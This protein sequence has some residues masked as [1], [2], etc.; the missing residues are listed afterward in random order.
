MAA[1]GVADGSEGSFADEG[2]GFEEIEAAHVVPDG[3]HGAAG[4]AEFLEV[5][6]VVGK[7][8]VGGREA[9]V[10]A[11]DEFDAV[12]VVGAVAEADDD[13]VTGGVGLVQGEDSKGARGVGG[14]F[15]DEQVGG[16]AQAGLGLV[17]EEFAGVVAAV[18]FFLNFDV[19]IA[20]FFG[21]GQGAH[22]ILHGAQDGGALFALPIVGSGR[23][24]GGERDEARRRPGK[25]ES[26]L[27]RHASL[28][29]LPPLRIES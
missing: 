6:R 2:E 14:A 24:K 11:P 26:A 22:D 12:F 23:R 7:Q 16:D 13:F 21:A 28:M 4:V 20:A 27:A 19:E 18:G 5:G 1:E 17:G 10:A 25:K 15:R 8:R 3:F 9:D 29:V